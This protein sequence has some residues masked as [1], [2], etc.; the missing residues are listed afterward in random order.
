[1]DQFQ[2]YLAGM[3]FWWPSTKIVQA[4]MIRQKTWLL[5]G[6]VYFP[7]YIYIETLKIFLS[8]TTGQSSM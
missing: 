8:E 7:P 2:Y 6:W 3:C 1:M 5:G 4:L